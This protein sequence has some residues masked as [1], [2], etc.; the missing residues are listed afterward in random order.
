[1]EFYSETKQFWVV[2]SFP[3]ITSPFGSKL[4]ISKQNSS[5]GF[6]EKMQYPY[7]QAATFIPVFSNGIY[8]LQFPS[9]PLMILPY[10]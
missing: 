9:T 10:I 4:P 6:L 2:F 7:A 8:F 5:W 1:M 3:T